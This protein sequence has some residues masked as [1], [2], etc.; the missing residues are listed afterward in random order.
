MSE[1]LTIFKINEIIEKTMKEKLIIKEFDDFNEKHDIK[2]SKK[3]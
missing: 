3:N 2:Y 1:S